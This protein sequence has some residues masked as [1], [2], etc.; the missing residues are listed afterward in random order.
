MLGTSLSLAALL[1]A[2][3]LAFL[4]SPTTAS[5]AAA[6]DAPTIRVSDSRVTVGKRVTV[7]GR[8]P[9]HRQIVLQL[10]TA[11]NGWQQVGS[12]TTGR[13]GAYSLRAPNWYGTHRLRVEMPATPDSAGA[14]SDT[15]TVK[16][17]M[18][19]RPKGRSSDWTWLGRSGP[20]WEPCGPITFR[21]NPRGG[22]ARATA[23][24]KSAVRKVGRVA[25][26]RFRYLGTTRSPVR[27]GTYG[28][29]PAG[30][31]VIID[32]QTPKQ[33]PGLS[34]RVAGIGG[35]WIQGGRRFDGY[36]VLDQTARLGR[37]TWRQVMRHEM[38]HVLGL[39]HARAPSQLMFGTSSRTNRR[40]GAGDLAGLHR[41]GA[42]RGC[43]PDWYARPS[44]PERVDSPEAPR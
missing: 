44:E 43:L 37:G 13:D 12:T 29:H 2:A 4:A 8:A 16:A 3:H 40:W 14:A 25:G 26:F 17:T 1:V 5:T 42:S 28:I 9:S 27:R 6:P 18:S 41:I 15:L 23:D 24:I 39:S 35:H 38:V 32:W 30:T 11:E 36:V 34:G 21:I 19:Y 7:S 31:D 33:D 20:R 10:R 22:Y